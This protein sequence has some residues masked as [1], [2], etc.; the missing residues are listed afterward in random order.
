MNYCANI[1]SM[2]AGEEIISFFSH[3]IMYRNLPLRPER[4]VAQ[5]LLIK[6]EWH[7]VLF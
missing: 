3:D 4:D 1:F 6:G 5:Y 7:S 2:V